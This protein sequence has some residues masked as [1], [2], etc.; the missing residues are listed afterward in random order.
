MSIVK[1]STFSKKFWCGNWRYTLHRQLTM[2]FLCNFDGNYSWHFSS[3]L[4]LI[5]ES[6][7]F[8]LK[9]LEID[10]NSI[11]YKLLLGS[12]IL[13]NK[14]FRIDT[15]HLTNVPVNTDYQFARPDKYIPTDESIKNSY[16]D[17]FCSIITETRFLQPFGNFSEKTLFSIYCRLP[18]I[19]VGPPYTIK[20]LNEL[21]FKTFNHWWDESYDCEENHEQ[22]LIKIF[23]VI[24]YIDSKSIDELESMYESMKPILDH[25]FEM[26]KNF[27]MDR[28][29]L[30]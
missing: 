25:N 12:N 2:T 18:F 1:N 16:T 5:Q 11:Y 15:A 22:R 6:L 17:S 30:F 4:K 10:N 8:N 20:Y 24:D 7:Y 29:E 9:K 19:L 3:P 28:T 23:K 13:E 26:L 27:P 14:N 21:G